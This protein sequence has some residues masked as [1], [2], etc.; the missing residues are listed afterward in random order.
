MVANSGNHPLSPLPL[1]TLS[2]PPGEIEETFPP[3][4]PPF[5]TTPPGKPIWLFIKGFQY[6]RGVLWMNPESPLATP[7][8]RNGSSPPGFTL[9]TPKVLVPTC[10]VAGFPLLTKQGWFGAADGCSFFQRR[11][12]PFF[13]NFFL[14]FSLPQNGN[15]SFLSSFQAILQTVEKILQYLF[16]FFFF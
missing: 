16:F 1:F 15:Y 10:L 9:M 3:P 2:A 8:R 11:F 12:F 7:P 6:I 14:P 13:L 4:P 5:R